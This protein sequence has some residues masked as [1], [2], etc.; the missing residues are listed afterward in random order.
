MTYNPINGQAFTAAF[1]GA[2]A[3]MAVNGW[4]SSATPSNYTQV[5]AIAG[6]FAQA[7]DTA[8]NNAAT[9]NGLEYSAIQQACAQE[10]TQRGPGPLANPKFTEVANWEIPAAA[11]AVLALQCDAYYVAQG[12]TPPSLGGSSGFVAQVDGASATFTSTDDTLVTTILS[13]PVAAF[14][15]CSINAWAELSTNQEFGVDLQ[16]I[17]GLEI[18]IDGGTSWIADTGSQYSYGAN[19]AGGPNLCIQVNLFVQADGP[20]TGDVMLRFHLE[21]GATIPGSGL[22]VT[23]RGTGVFL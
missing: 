20:A 11:C 19:G 3:G 8:W 23:L 15:S 14:T 9:L 6:A 18:S 13:A 22:G 12:I 2:V 1:S 7:F 5:C 16:G 4:I 21:S 10:F 17:A